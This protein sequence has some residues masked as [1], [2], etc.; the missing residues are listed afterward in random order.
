MRFFRRIMLASVTGV[1]DIDTLPDTQKLYYTATAKVTPKSNSLGSPVIANKWDATTGEGVIVCMRDIEEIGNS[2]FETKRELISITMPDSIAKIGDYVFSNC[3]NLSQMNIPNSVRY[4]GTYFLHN[5]ASHVRI[6]I[7]DLEDFCKITAPELNGSGPFS[8]KG[9][10]Y[11]NGIEVEELIIPDNITTISAGLFNSC[12]SIKSVVIPNNVTSIGINSFSTCSRLSDVVIGDGVTKIKS[13]TFY[14]SALKNVKIGK[15]VST[16]DNEALY[17]SARSTT[18]DFSSHISI[19]YIQ[20]EALYIIDGFHTVNIIVPDSLYDEWI[21][22]TNWSQY[23]DYII[24][25]S[26]WDASQVTE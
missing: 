16:I 21:A 11:L 18:Y 1:I 23:A 22:A 5:A 20:P 13:R 9:T 24:K 10:L 2:A 12:S 25:K 26:D 19:P 4:I 17:S 14:Q 8:Y 7:T 15:N 6:D 3:T